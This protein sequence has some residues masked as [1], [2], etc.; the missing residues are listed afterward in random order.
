MKLDFFFFS[1]VAVCLIEFT[2]KVFELGHQG[3][4]SVCHRL[5]S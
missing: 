3:G 1:K 5:G 2:L 4:L